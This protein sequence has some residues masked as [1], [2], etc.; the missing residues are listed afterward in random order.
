MGEKKSVK[1]CQEVRS[2]MKKTEELEEEAR[3][4]KGLNQ[5]S[6]WCVQGTARRMSKKEKIGNEVSKVSQ[7]CIM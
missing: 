2:C 6:V 7:D 1:I 5:K 4:G 3:E